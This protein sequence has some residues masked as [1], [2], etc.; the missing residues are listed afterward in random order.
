MASIRGLVAQAGGLERAAWLSAASPKLYAS[1]LRLYIRRN[2]QNYSCSP[3]VNLQNTD[4]TVLLELPAAAYRVG[5]AKQDEDARDERTEALPRG[6]TD[7]Y[8]G[9]R[10]N[11]TMHITVPLCLTAAAVNLSDPWALR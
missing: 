9:C 3:A 10:M 2:W 7:A 11:P 1:A 6:S 4:S 5:L 8:C